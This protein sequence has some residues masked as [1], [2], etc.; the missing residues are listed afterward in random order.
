[1]HQRVVKQLSYAREDTLSQ[2]E[3]KESPAEGEGAL[4]AGSNQGCYFLCDLNKGTWALASLPV[5]G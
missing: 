2:K 4:G 3:G 1:M 5:M